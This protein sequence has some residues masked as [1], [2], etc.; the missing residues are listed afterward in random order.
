MNTRN[1]I[2]L[3][4]ALCLV[5]LLGGQRA[6]NSKLGVAYLPAIDY[7]PQDAAY[8]LDRIAERVDLLLAASGEASVTLCLE[9]AD[10]KLHEAL[11]MVRKSEAGYAWIA[12]GLHKDYIHRGAQQIEAAAPE[13]I[14]GQRRHFANTLIRQIAA[15]AHQYPQ[16]PEQIRAFSLVP[17]VSA[18]LY[19]IDQQRTLMAAS[20]VANLDMS[21][22]ELEAMIIAMRAA[23]R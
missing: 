16:L 21:E 23:D 14:P 6:M 18:T 17:L 4:T 7:S 19:E 11:Q 9:F 10:E 8:P 3:V 2:L 13:N 22:S 1:A 15:L 20:Q 12:V 5:A